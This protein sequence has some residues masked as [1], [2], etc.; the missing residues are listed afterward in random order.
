MPQS[1]NDPS[2]PID[3]HMQEFLAL[4]GVTGLEPSESDEI[5]RLLKLMDASYPISHDDR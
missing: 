2:I 3:P 5:S 1:D 4:M